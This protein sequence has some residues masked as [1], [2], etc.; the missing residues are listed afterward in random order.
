VWV[1]RRS[2][3]VSTWHAAQAAPD[4]LPGEPL[5]HHF[6]ADRFL[7]LLPFVD[8][9][10]HVGGAAAWSDA[11]LRATFVIDDPNLRR[12]TYGFLNYRS[13]AHEAERFGYHAGI[14]MVPLDGAVASPAVAGIFRDH[15]SL[16]V[17]V[18]GN[19]HE[20]AELGKDLAPGEML[21][22]AL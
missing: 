11:P 4:V 21:S 12:E 16:S 8:F 5:K 14:A 1:V 13:L 22:M 20:R 10:Q 6:Q 19:D 17:L 18:H 3:G 15:P 9:L 7:A 2:P